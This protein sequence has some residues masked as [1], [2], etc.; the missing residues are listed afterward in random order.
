MKSGDDR[1]Y[2]PD[3]VARRDPETLLIGLQTKSRSGAESQAARQRWQLHS[4]L[5]QN[6]IH[7]I[8]PNQVIT[9]EVRSAILSIRYGHPITVFVTDLEAM[10]AALQSG[11]SLWGSAREIG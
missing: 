7:V 3:L 5:N 9:R 10:A 8:T 1:S 6:Q 11:E 4:T 2:W